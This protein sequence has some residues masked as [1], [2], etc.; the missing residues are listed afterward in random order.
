[1]KP[2][3]EAALRPSWFGRLAYRAFPIRRAVVL[4]NLNTAFGKELSQDQI[5]RLAQKFYDHLFTTFFE[6]VRLTW[7]S[8]SQL[9]MGLRVEGRDNVMAASAENKG[10]IL[11]GGH[12]GNW[13]MAPIMCTEHFREF[14]GRFHVLRRQLVNKTVERLLFGRYKT[15]GLNVLPKRN[16]L[17]RILDVLAENDAVAFIMDQHAKA[18]KDGVVVDF[19]GKKAGTFK[20]LAIVARASGAPVVPTYCFRDNDGSHVMRFLEPLKWIEHPDSDEEIALNT[21]RYNETIEKIILEH[22]EQWLW[23]HR[24]W[25]IKEPAILS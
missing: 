20:S 13:E 24:R 16:S 5:K 14:K 6:N 8:P 7:M 15:A 11:L 21:R 9:K 12:F 17:S 23:V 18:G 22:P 25:K 2:F 10:V 19:F 3:P 1:M 4:E